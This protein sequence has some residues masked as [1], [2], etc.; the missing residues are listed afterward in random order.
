M[1][2]LTNTVREQVSAR[3]RQAPV[4]DWMPRFTVVVGVLLVVVVG[5]QAL[6]G[7]FRGEGE[8]PLAPPRQYIPP[9]VTS[10]TA[11]AGPSTTA[12]DRPDPATTVPDALEPPRQGTVTVARTDG[13]VAELDAAAVDI[14]RRAAVAR[15]TGE[16]S[17]VP[18]QGVPSGA[19]RPGADPKVTTIQLRDLSDGRLE[20]LVGVEPDP[21][22]AIEA[23][24]VIV[25]AVDGQWRWLVP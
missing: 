11:G 6:F 4:P 19:G 2:R 15:Y 21:R 23:V 22:S 12:S 9:A 8:A 1:G 14:A 18:T 10:T 20:F 25:V 5:V 7:L 24:D 16:F 17:N 13:G 3:A